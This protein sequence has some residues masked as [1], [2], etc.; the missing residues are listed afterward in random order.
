M[1]TKSRLGNYRAYALFTV[2]PTLVCIVL[3]MRA[4]SYN[5]AVEKPTLFGKV[6]VR[7]L[8]TVT[9][10]GEVC[11]YDP[12]ATAPSKD[13]VTPI[14]IDCPKTFLRMLTKCPALEPPPKSIPSQLRADY[15]MSGAIEV[16]DFYLY[17]RYS[18]SKGLTQ[19]WKHDEIAEAVGSPTLYPATQNFTT[20]TTNEGR[21][22]EQAVREFQSGVAGKV[23]IVWGS[24]KPWVEVILARAGAKHIVTVEYGE[25]ISTYPD[26]TVTTPEKFAAFMLTKKRSF[27]FAATF[28]SL[29]HSGLGRYGDAMDPFGDMQAAAETWCAL[30]PGGLFFLGLPSVDRIASK[31]ELHWTAHR[32][33]GPRRLAQM[34]RGFKY[35]DTIETSSTGAHPHASLIHVLQKPR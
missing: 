12:S 5:D 21:Y 9:D 22:F 20:Y 18:G 32:F 7:L 3:L 15:T 26:M 28:S 30:R 35:L 13:R 10:C 8:T 27:D 34:F 17:H 2:V 29:E 31:D 24:E 14:S 16:F 23:G 1:A 4:D 11:R 25:I 6:D 19:E 33:Y